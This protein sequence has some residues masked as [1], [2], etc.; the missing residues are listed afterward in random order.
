ML[1]WLRFQTHFCFYTCIQCY[2]KWMFLQIPDCNCIQVEDTAGCL[3]HLSLPILSHFCS[4]HGN[5]TCVF[6]PADPIFSG[7]RKVYEDIGIEMLE[8]AFEGYNVC[9]FAY[10]Q[11]GSGKSYTMM[12]KNEPGQQGIIPQVCAACVCGGEGCWSKAGQLASWCWSQCKAPL[13]PSWGYVGTL[14]FGSSKLTKCPTPWG[15]VWLHP[16]QYTSTSQWDIW[17]LWHLP[18]RSLN[19][20]KSSPQPLEHRGHSIPLVSPWC[21]PPLPAGEGGVGLYIDFCI[22]YLMHFSWSEAKL[23]LKFYSCWTLG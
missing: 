23:P 1:E 12:G 8:H 5:L 11:T 17:G 15:I 18:L 20:T 7:Q 2:K 14:K 3:S 21:V 10:G 6:Q 22:R 16:P 4:N 19:L 13:P 9:I